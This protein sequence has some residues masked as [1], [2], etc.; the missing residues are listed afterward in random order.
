MTSTILSQVTKILEE[1]HSF[2]T[3]HDNFGLFQYESQPNLHQR[4]IQG[5]DVS[6]LPEQ[7]KLEWK[8][9]Y[10]SRP[11]ARHVMNSVKSLISAE[12]GDE[13]SVGQI[14]LTLILSAQLAAAVGQ[15]A[16][17]FANDV[18]ASCWNNVNCWI[19]FYS[20]HEF[21][22][23]VFGVV[24]FTV[25]DITWNG[26]SILTMRKPTESEGS[27]RMRESHWKTS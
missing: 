1:Y 26:F 14:A 27:K 9:Y 5:E 7:A 3:A 11:F 18:S 16:Q 13:F 15:C 2:R 25:E 23:Q 21:Q 10:L 12:T 20:C 19:G 6:K 17:D 24:E 8:S 4:R 22:P